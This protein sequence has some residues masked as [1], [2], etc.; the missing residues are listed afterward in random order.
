MIYLL[1]LLI[2]L[3][4]V[5]SSE[6]K[7]HYHHYEPLEFK[8]N[9]FYNP[10]NW[11][12]TDKNTI[13]TKLNIYTNQGEFDPNNLIGR[14]GLGFPSKSDGFGYTSWNRL[15]GTNA[16]FSWNEGTGGTGWFWWRP[17]TEWY[18]LPHEKRRK[19]LQLELLITKIGGEPTFPTGYSITFPDYNFSR[20]VRVWVEFTYNPFNF[21]TTKYKKSKLIP[22]S[23]GPPL[24]L[25]KNVITI[26]GGK[27]V[28]LNNSAEL[29]I[30]VNIQQGY[31]DLTLTDGKE[32]N[33]NNWFS[34]SLPAIVQTDNQIIFKAIINNESEPPSHF[35]ARYHIK[36]KDRNNDRYVNLKIIL[37][38]NPFVKYIGHLETENI[39]EICPSFN[40]INLSEKRLT[41]NLP[42]LIKQPCRHHFSHQRPQHK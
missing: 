19:Y 26:P 14:P 9:K 11:K 40:K 22:L 2:I 12:W 37:L 8:T 10:S 27:W 21:I 16:W 15:Q 20:S 23:Y 36:V 34:W 4:I 7:E 24:I 25:E 1:V 39:S 38:N 3:L 5:L 35:P 30:P 17:T 33:S 13:T 6:I 32:R 42:I 18:K 29:Y 28:I 31:F 41:G